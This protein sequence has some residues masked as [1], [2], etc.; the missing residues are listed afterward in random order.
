ML[1]SCCSNICFV[2]AFCMHL[3][4]CRFLG[5]TASC[6]CVRTEHFG[7][8]LSLGK[9]KINLQFRSHIRRNVHNLHNS[10]SIFSI[11]T[12]TRW[13]WVRHA[14]RMGE[15]IYEHIILVGKFLGNRLLRT[16]NR[17]WEND[18]NT[19]LMR[20][21]CENGRSIITNVT[22][23]ILISCLSKKWIYLYDW[24]NISIQFWKST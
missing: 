3:K 10:P 19:V 6:K 12:F 21:R 1:V 2:W 20:I 18:T 7:K 23:S 17:R 22:Y 15:K 11:V 4:L 9:F 13:P 24:H 5:K 16:P 14:S 8:Y